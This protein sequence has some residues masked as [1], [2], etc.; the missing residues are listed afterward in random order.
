M[1]KKRKRRRFG[2]A[3][4]TKITVSTL[5]RNRAKKNRKEGE[6][7]KNRW[8]EN[9]MATSNPLVRCHSTMKTRRKGKYTASQDPLVDSHCNV[10]NVRG[11]ARRVGNY[12]LWQQ[13]TPQTAPFI[14]NKEERS[15][16]KTPFSCYGMKKTGMEKALYDCHE[17]ERRK[18]AYI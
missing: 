15:K 9:S 1:T 7:K 6:K 17:G 4:K 2:A 16:K 8:R 18:K 5:Y 3:I 12:G 11:E 10:K 14:S 13:K